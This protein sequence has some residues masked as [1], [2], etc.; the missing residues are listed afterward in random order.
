VLRQLLCL[1]SLH[2]EQAEV[3]PA[4]LGAA[5]E[6]AL[7]AQIYRYSSCSVREAVMVCH[8]SVNQDGTFFYSPQNQ[9]KGLTIV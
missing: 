6:G 1:L 9:N 7:D 3:D 4:D 8:P 5:T 2:L